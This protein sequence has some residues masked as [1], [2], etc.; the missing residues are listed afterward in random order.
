M[1]QK[2]TILFLLLLLVIFQISVLP[3]FFPENSI[4]NI[5]LVMLVFWT[6]F[7]GIEKTWK[8]AMLGGLVSDLFLFVPVGTNILSF[9]VAII[10]VNYLARRFLVTP[11]AWR[12]AILIILVASGVLVNEIVLTLVAKILIAFQKTAKNIPMLINWSLAHKI[13]NSVIIFMVLYWPI[14]KIE[15]IL[16]LYGSRTDPKSNV[17]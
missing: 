4:P 17:R 1:T 12:F 16:N 7:K 3:N 11:R 14:K 10:L 6:A 8:S 5:L 15:A 2:I 9:L 13:I